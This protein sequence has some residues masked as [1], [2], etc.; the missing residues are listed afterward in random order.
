[1]SPIWLLGMWT[2][3]PPSKVAPEGVMNIKLVNVGW[4]QTEQAS[5]SIDLEVCSTLEVYS[6]FFSFLIIKNI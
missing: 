5:L 2:M 4:I 1:M 6:I 3:D